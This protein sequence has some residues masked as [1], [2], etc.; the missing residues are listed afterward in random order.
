MKKDSEMQSEYDFNHGVRGRYAKRYAKGTNVIVL[1]PGVAKMFPNSKSVN[2]ALKTLVD[3]ARQS[4]K[5]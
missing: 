5:K 1:E 4:K 2:D 3:I